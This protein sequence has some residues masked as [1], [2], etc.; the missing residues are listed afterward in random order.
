MKNRPV[1]ATLTYEKGQTGR[2]SH[3]QDKA[4]RFVP[5]IMLKSLKNPGPNLRL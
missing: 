1:D 3:K 5:L 2:L 4:N